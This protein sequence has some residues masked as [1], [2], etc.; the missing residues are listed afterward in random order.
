MQQAPAAQ[1]GQPLV[2]LAAKTTELLITGVAQGQHGIRQL[3]TVAALLTLQRLPEVRGTVG[4]LAITER[5]GNEHHAGSAAQLAG[6]GRL[7]ATELHLQACAAQA[8][9]AALGQQFAVAGLRSPYHL[10]QRLGWRRGRCLGRG[11]EQPG[12]QAVNEH[13]PAGRQRRTGRQAGHSVGARLGQPQQKTLQIVALVVGQHRG[14][15]G[16]QA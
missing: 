13:T 3:S 9:G 2:Q 5:A 15:Q 14:R 6:A 12:Q 1:L 11:R 10:V 7:H 8:F 16:V 4:G